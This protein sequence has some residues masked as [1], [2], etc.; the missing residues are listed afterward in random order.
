MGNADGIGYYRVDHPAEMI[1][2]LAKDVGKLSPG[3]RLSLLSDEWAIVRAGRH[4][5]GAWLDLA[6]GFGGERDALVLSTL[7]SR[8]DS[9]DQDLTTPATRD[10]YC[11]WVRAL[12]APA[13]S[14]L[15]WTGS[16]NE[17]A[18]R[19]TLRAEVVTALGDAGDPG[20]MKT[21]RA[22]IDDLLRESVSIDSTLRRPIIDISAVR[23]DV[24][25]YEQY[26]A[27]SRSAEDPE[28]RYRFLY[29][30]T[31]F[32]DP[33]LVRRTMEYALGPEV[34]TQDTK[35]LVASMIAND[36]TRAL[37]WELLQQRW[38]DLQKKAGESTSN[39]SIVAAVGTFCDAEHAQ[40]VDQFFTA[41]PVP[42]AAR[43][44]QQ[45]KERI[46]SCVAF[47]GAEAPHLATW[48]QAHR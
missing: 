4:Q 1:P 28:E 18:D 16:A 37:A 43:T 45:A 36:D 41:H 48:L 14:D 23:G 12:L 15:G 6:S 46:R 30:L 24:K 38:D 3:E 19:R 22:K 11:A 20:V 40:Q 7:I 33:A 9:I 39:G 32:S 10:A 8:L 13:M 47:R 17:P 34:R 21:A 35:L 29:G 26:Q 2:L 27:R 5:I 42:D 31:E 25:L 44:L